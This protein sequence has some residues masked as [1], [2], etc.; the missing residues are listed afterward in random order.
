[1]VAGWVLDVVEIM[2]VEAW[3]EAGVRMVGI[4]RVYV[5]RMDMVL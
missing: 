1:M 5:C 2:R 3:S 4:G